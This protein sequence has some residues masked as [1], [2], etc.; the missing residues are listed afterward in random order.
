[1]LKTSI[2]MQM[3]YLVRNKFSI[4]VSLVLLAAISINFLINLDGNREILYISEMYSFEKMLTL[5]DWSAV[6][7]F[8]MEYY[9]LLVVIPTACTYIIDKNSGVN[10]YIKARVG[11]R[12]YWYGKMISVFILTLFIFTVPYFMEIILNVICFSMGSNGDPSG[13]AF[14]QTIGTEDRYF[15]SD[16]LLQNRVIYAVIMTLLFGAVSAILATFNF[17]VTTL[18][19][20]KIKIFTY[21]PV[22]I[23]LFAMLI[24]Q[25]IVNL[26]FAVDY[27][28]ILRMFETTTVKNYMA[29]LLFLTALL[30][31]S[32]GLIEWKI[33]KEELL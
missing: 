32:V 14:W 9:P 18:S 26:H 33:R 3:S 17:A 7:Y 10:T 8:M 30:I 15:L 5:S 23:L 4:F 1:M 11:K 29:Y 31:I 19:V 12:N 28:F 20:F 22:Y 16:I 2:G 13:L 21:F 6:G 27:R 24:L 25:K